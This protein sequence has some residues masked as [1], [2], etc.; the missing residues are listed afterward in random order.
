MIG[1]FFRLFWQNV[2][3]YRSGAR[4]TK[5]IASLELRHKEHNNDPY[6]LHNN[7]IER[8]NS[9]YIDLVYRASP[10]Y[11]VHIEKTESASTYSKLNTN[12]SE[13]TSIYAPLS[14]TYLRLLHSVI[15][16]VNFSSLVN[17]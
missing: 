2:N 11:R 4:Y 13:Y 12:D 15:Y 9:A 14:T 16:G 10:V 8:D 7:T 1:E 3:A 5:S 17:V 6:S